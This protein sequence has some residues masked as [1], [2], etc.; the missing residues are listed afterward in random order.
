MCGGARF[1][2]PTTTVWVVNVLVRV[3]I[4]DYLLDGVMG[5][6]KTKK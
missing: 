1:M 5:K 3:Y 2:L 4:L 6:G